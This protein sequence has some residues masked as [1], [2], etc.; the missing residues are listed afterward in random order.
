MSDIGADDIAVL[1]VFGVFQWQMADHQ[2]IFD[3]H[4]VRDAMDGA[5]LCD[6]VF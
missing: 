2:R 4:G 5:T 3:R 6:D 1:T